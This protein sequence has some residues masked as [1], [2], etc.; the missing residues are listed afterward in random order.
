MP[1]PWRKTGRGTHMDNLGITS[2][3]STYK[4]LNG[5]GIPCIGFGTWQTPD[6]NVAYESVLAALK[7]GYRHI[8]TATAYGNEESVG[9]A[10]NDFL[11]TGEVK[12]SELFIT[13]KLHNRDHGYEATEKAI[14]NSLSLLGLDYLD[15][16]LI[17]WPN[18]I[19]FRENWAEANAGSWKAME[20]A[21]AKGKI[22]AIGLSN[23][24]ERHIDRLMETA[25]VP[26]MVDQIKICPGIAQTD[27]VEFCKARKMAVEG[28]SPLG[29]G[30]TFRS[31]VLRKIAQKY[32]KTVAQVCVRWSLQQGAIPLPKSV[33]AER[34]A[35][36]SQVFDFS[37][38]IE[39]CQAIAEI[40]YA[41]LGISPQRNP[42]ENTF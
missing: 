14:E 41:E 31:E 35:Q 24:F 37:L 40:N 4:L 11:K 38:D 9:R 36:N 23:F 3:S 1:V 22:R 30:G 33:N 21:Y 7:C 16:Y 13:T 25:E 2:L 20:E 15:L 26:P 29:T 17:H 42:D 28:Y 34:I 12:R 10:I 39:D 18:P 19:F 32:G 6:G 5:V 27:L 8:D